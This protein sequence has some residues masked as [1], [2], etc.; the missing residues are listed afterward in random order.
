MKAGMTYWIKKTLAILLLGVIG[1]LMLNN[2]LYMHL[3]RMADGTLIVHAH[4]FSKSNQTDDPAQ[5]HKHTKVEILVFSNLL[6]LFAV[7]LFQMV[8]SL[9]QPKLIKRY[10]LLQFLGLRSRRITSNRAP[11]LY[12]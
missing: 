8:K 11:P 7:G 10:Y 9:V 1:L 3:H 2:A 5:T 6:I 4:P 12:A